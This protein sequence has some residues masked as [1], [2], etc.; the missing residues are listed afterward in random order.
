M[1]SSFITCYRRLYVDIP[2]FLV[3]SSNLA[4]KFVIYI[5]KGVL[6]VKL[7]FETTLIFLYERWGPVFKSYFCKPYI[8]VLPI[9]MTLSY[10]AKNFLT[11]AILTKTV[12]CLQ[13]LLLEWPPFSYMNGDPLFLF[14]FFADHKVIPIWNTFIQIRWIT[15]LRSYEICIK[16]NHFI[17]T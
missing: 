1:T 3:M 7:N 4:K 14:L 12:F 9:L 17:Y 10:L 15:Q 5:K 11:F 13:F 16:I 8:D 6:H 2:P